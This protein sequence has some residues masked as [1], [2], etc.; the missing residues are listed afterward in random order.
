V[1]DKL[2]LHRVL[3]HEGFTMT[4]GG[5]AITVKN[6]SMKKNL[7]TLMAKTRN[8][9]KDYYSFEIGY[10]AVHRAKEK[11]L[12]LTIPY[13]NKYQGEVLDLETFNLDFGEIFQYPGYES[14]YLILQEKGKINY[15]EINKTLKIILTEI[16]EKLVV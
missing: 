10:Q 11:E 8:I 9:D 7:I 2:D 13:E 16:L 3:F 4:S 6:I 15:A 12:T 14:G 1:L 5:K